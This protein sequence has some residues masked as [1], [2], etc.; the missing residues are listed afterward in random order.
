[1]EFIQFILQL[2]WRWNY[3]GTSACQANELHRH[4]GK[5]LCIPL[6]IWHQS[7]LHPSIKN[8]SWRRRH[9]LFSYL[10]PRSTAISKLFWCFIC[11]W[12]ETREDLCCVAEFIYHSQELATAGQEAEDPE[13][14]RGFLRAH[15]LYLMDVGAGG[16][17]DLVSEMQ[18]TCI[19]LLTGFYLSW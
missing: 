11:D 12:K 3:G 17:L 7:F 15:L 13:S 5:V 2:L 8:L 14:W 1:M 10:Q 4:L 6:L 19:V 9:E 16:D 18:I